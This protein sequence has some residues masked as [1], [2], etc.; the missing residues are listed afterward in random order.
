MC[1]YGTG[2]NNG[3]HWCMGLAFTSPTSVSSST[4]IGG[5]MSITDELKIHTQT[6][7]TTGN[8]YLG[9]YVE[10]SAPTEVIYA[11]WAEEAA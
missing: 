2:G 8:V 3:A 7:S 4:R 1:M 6:I 10:G 5:G 9:T 11:L